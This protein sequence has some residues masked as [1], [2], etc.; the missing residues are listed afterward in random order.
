MK[1]VDGNTTGIWDGYVTIFCGE[2]ENAKII[3]FILTAMGTSDDQCVTLEDCRKMIGEE[4]PITVMF[5]DLTKGAIYRYGNY[6]D[7]K[8]YKIGE[9]VGYC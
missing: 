6:S 2:N 9:T 4:L 7:N 5:E 1:E 3:R 8:W